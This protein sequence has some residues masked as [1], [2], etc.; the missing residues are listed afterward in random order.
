MVAQQPTWI[1]NPRIRDK[2]GVEGIRGREGLGNN[3]AFFSP[4]AFRGGKCAL[5]AGRHLRRYT[6]AGRR[7]GQCPP[8]HTVGSGWLR[9]P[10]CARGSGGGGGG[11]RPNVH[12]AGEGGTAAAVRASAQ[13]GAPRRR[14]RARAPG[15]LCLRAPAWGYKSLAT[16]CR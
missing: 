9:A 7:A 16:C 1:R 13:A 8:L 14:G 3:K 11:Q 10:G 4:S 12:T 15:A 5:S 6:L 2:G